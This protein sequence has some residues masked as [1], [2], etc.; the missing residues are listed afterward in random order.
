MANPTHD[1]ILRTLRARGKCTVQELADTAGVYPVS[2]RHHMANLQAEGLVAAEEV[3]HGVGRPR[4]LYTLTEKA[5]ELF[6]SRYYRLTQRLLDQMKDSLPE[7]MV[8]QLFSSVAQ[9]MA[10]DYAGELAGLPLERRLERLATYLSGEGFEAE[11]EE[12]EGRLLIHQLSC[13]WLRMGREHPE[14]C[15]VDQSFIATALA[16]PV[17]RVTC[18]LNGETHC[19]FAIDRRA[20]IPEAPPNG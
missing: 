2:V 20:P 7:P 18:L 13:P 3:R 6:P 4:L 14:V 9:T 5:L 19:T 16:L 12:R 17:E 8:R 11:V 15:L 1:L 10:E